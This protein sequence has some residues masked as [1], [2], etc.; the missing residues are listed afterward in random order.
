M[1]LKNDIR[2]DLM[3]NVSIAKVGRAKRKAKDMMLGT[4]MEQY[5][6]LWNYA[7][8]VRD[9][10]A[11]STVKM[12]IDKPPDGS[13]GT[14]QRLYYYLYACKKGFLDGCRPIIGLDGCFLKTA[15]G[16]QLLSVLGRDGNDNMVP[17][18]FA[19]VEVER[20]DSWKWFLELLMADLGMGRD[21]IPWTFISDRQKGLVH[22][23]NELFPN[24]EHRF[25]LRHMYQNFNQKFKGK[26]MK[27]MFWAA[28]SAGNERE[29][30]MAMIELEKTNKEAAEWLSRIPPALWSRSHFT[31]YSKCDILVNNLNESFNNYILEARELPIIGM[32]EWIRRRLMQRIQTKRSGMQKFQGEICPNIAEKIDKNQKLS[33]TFVATWDGGHKLS[34]CPCM[35]GGV[36]RLPIKN[37]VHA[38]YTRAEYLK[39][40]AYT[41]TPVPSDIYWITAE[42]ESI[43]PPA[44]RRMP[45]R[46]KKLRRRA[47]YEPKKGQVSTR[48]GL[49]A[50]EASA[51]EPIAESST[52]PQSTSKGA[53]T[54]QSTTMTSKQAR[55]PVH[56]TNMSGSNSADATTAT[57]T[58]TTAPTITDVLRKLRPKRSKAIQP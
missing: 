29:W 25:C 58:T 44:V 30:K 34:L 4:D 10:N 51:A 55:K 52:Q 22:A 42:E 40:Y 8:T 13:R 14:F 23:V 26:E 5:Q 6:K 31:G 33:R 36:C 35:C 53:P 56:G 37:Y 11:G 38:C 3:I 7:A 16:G 15:F 9:T 57:A 43:N 39:T 24:S 17:I 12:Q 19:V 21:N 1:G 54:A 48:K 28:A 18:A 41:I 27:D 2:R 20:Y 46:P 45:G 32:L 49:V 47:Q 50:P